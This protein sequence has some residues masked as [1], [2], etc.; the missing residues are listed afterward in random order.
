MLNIYWKIS[1]I[2]SI[3]SNRILQFF[4]PNKTTRKNCFNQVF[5]SQIDISVT[6]TKIMRKKL[7]FRAWYYFRQ[8]WGTY[9]AFIF[10][11]VNTLTVTYYLAIEK[12]PAL[13]EIFPSFLIY[14]AVVTIVG[15]PLLIGIGYFHFK[16][17]AAY[18]SEQ[19]ITAESNPYLFKLPP[20]YWLEVLFP[21]YLVITD[22]MVKLSKNEKLTDEELNQINELRKKI[23]VLLKGGYIGHPK[24]SE[25]E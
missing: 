19:D 2:E 17:S 22:M 20:G 16:R 7:G 25:K 11:A 5:S 14:S 24:Y 3:F 10:S 1:R 13:K 6:D 9:F 23:N 8:G 15:I 4:P 18:S 12:A 21:L